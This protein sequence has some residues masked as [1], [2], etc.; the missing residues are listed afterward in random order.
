[1][2]TPIDIITTA[3]THDIKMV[4]EVIDNIMSNDLLY[5]PQKK[6]EKIEESSIIIYVFDRAYNSK[7]VKQEIIK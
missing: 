2:D 4:T 7:S 6:E 5:S 3:S 1:M